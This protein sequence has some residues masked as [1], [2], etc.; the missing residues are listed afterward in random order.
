MGSKPSSWSRVRPVLETKG[1]MAE[2][3]QQ[4]HV[5]LSVWVVYFEE[6]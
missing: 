5:W 6:R 4:R 1:F 3:V 2:G